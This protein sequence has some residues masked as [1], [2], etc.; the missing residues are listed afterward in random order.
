MTKEEEE[1]IKHII[2]RTNAYL[3]QEGIVY[4]AAMFLIKPKRRGIKTSD[5]IIQIINK[6]VIEQKAIEREDIILLYWLYKTD[7]ETRDTETI[8]DYVNGMGWKNITF[9]K[10]TFVNH[11]RMQRNAVS[12]FKA[13]LASAILEGNLLV[14]PIIKIQ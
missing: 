7:N 12:W 13:G 1:E 9:D 6:S 4:N 3:P 11:W 10:D 14:L 2:Q 5:L 8:N